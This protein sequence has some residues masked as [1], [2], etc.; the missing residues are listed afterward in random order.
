MRPNVL[1]L[2]LILGAGL[3]PRRV[4]VRGY[5]T[6]AAAHFDYRCY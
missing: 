2:L 3:M 5:N 1:Q 4:W 6:T